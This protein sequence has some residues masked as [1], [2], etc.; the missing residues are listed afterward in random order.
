MSRR[1]VD[2]SQAGFSVVL[3][4]FS[5]LILLTL[6]IAM[7]SMVVEDSDSS[8]LHVQE[9]QAFYAAHAGV[10]Y[11]I[12]KLST[13]WAWGGLPSPGKNVGAGYYWIA[14]PDGVD[15]TG[16]ALPSN[17]K[18]IISTGVVGTSTRQIQVQLSGGTISTYAGTGTAGYTGDLGAATAA[19][20][21]HPE[22]ITVAANGD[23]YYAD[24]DNNVI[25]KVTAATGI[26]TTVA[27]SGGNGSSGDGGLAILAKFKN[28]EGVFVVANGDLY[29]ADTGN[30]EIRKVTAL[31]GI[32]T[33]VVGST[34]PG[35]S[36][37]GGAAAAARLRL[38][39]AIV[40][41]ANGDMYIAD[42][43]NDAVRKVTAATGIATTYAG[44]GTTGYTGDGG[45]ATSARLSGPQGLVLAA[46][47]DLYIADTGNNVI[48]KVTAATGV[49]TTFAGTGTAGFLGDGGVATSARLNA[50]ESV[51]ISA[52]GELYIADAG[53][54]RIRRVSTGGT[55]T[56]VAGTGT[57]GSAGDG[58]LPTA[59]QL[60]S[61]HGI[62]VSTSGT[63]Y[64]SDRVNNEIRRVTGVFAVVAWV[65]TRT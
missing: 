49:I 45:A 37:D 33:L 54:N 4:V 1:R 18:R 41:A 43:G 42:T 63:Y 26:I 62:A 52:S 16:A 10:E 12:V 59:A 55:I 61:P 2:P 31:T 24:P 65:E 47:G 36:G 14:P 11:A 44:T 23:V 9:N 40:V 22:G 64:I 27:G 28:A 51:S 38:P 34:S 50:P 25:R 53:N 15:E 46:N 32:V 6:G 60:N 20:I 3:A 19:R 13:N 8:V 35:Y 48:R 29:L 56:T 30:H 39:A 57:A 58:G 5:I 7:V 17:T 21:A